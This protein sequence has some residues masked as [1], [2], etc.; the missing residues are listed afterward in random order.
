MASA[1]FALSYSSQ[2]AVLSFRQNG[3]PIRSERLSVPYWTWLDHFHREVIRDNTEAIFPE[4]LDQ[5]AE[6]GQP[7]LQVG[8]LGYFGYELKRESLPGYHYVPTT[9]DPDT[10]RADSELLFAS[11]VL[12]LDNYTGD[13]T[14]FNL[15][16]R[17][18]ADPIGDSIGAVSKVGLSEEEF[19]ALL[20]RVRDVFAAPL[21]P[22]YVEPHGLPSFVALDDEE[23]YSDTIRAAKAAIKDG[24]AYELTLTTKFKAESPKVDPYALYL[25]LRER[26]PAPYSAFMHFAAHDNTILS[27]SPERFISVDAN[28]VAEMKPI[29]GTLAV[30]PDFEENERRKTQLATD[31]KELAENLMIAQSIGGVKV[32]ERCFPPG[33]MTGAPK[34]RAVQILDALEQRDRGIYSGSI[35]YICASGTVDQSV[36][37]RTI[38]KAGEKLELSA[39]GAITWLSEEEKEWDEVMTKANAV[40]NALP[41]QTPLEVIADGLQVGA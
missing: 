22:P 31:V 13:W 21:S 33:S 40:A 35:G 34:L 15:V 28:G 6:V 39:G 41:R 36:V 10:E 9:E 26:N 37:I 2:S 12:R 38:V 7:L 27:S 32:I 20:A 4:L 25:D 8:L 3:K 30:S 19:S 16:R 23:S 17:S 14:M 5:E 24:E 1:T 18:D 11:T 29:K